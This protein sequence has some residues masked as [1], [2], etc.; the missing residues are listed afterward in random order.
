MPLAYNNDGEFARLLL[1]VS[2]LHDAES[3]RL[4]YRNASSSRISGACERAACQGGE[5]CWGGQMAEESA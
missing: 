4:R 5:R 1:K 2:D 3:I